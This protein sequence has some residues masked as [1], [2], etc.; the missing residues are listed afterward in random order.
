MRTHEQIDEFKPDRT[1]LPRALVRR[2]SAFAFKLG[3][4]V[5][6]GDLIA[7]VTDRRRSAAGRELY[8]VAVLG[9]DHGRP[10]RTFLGQYLRPIH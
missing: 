7:V 2:R 6:S 9:A 4:R 10:R 3:Q 8:D 5:S 1:L